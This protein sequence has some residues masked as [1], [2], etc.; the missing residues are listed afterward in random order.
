MEEKPKRRSIRDISPIDVYRLLPGTACKECGEPN[1]MA[2]A[3]RLVNGEVQLEDC[4]PLRT[5]EHQLRYLQL[6]ELL[7][8]A[9]R[10]VTFGSKGKAMT[11]GGKHVLLRHELTY[12]HPPPLAIEVSDRM[13][14]KEIEE[15]VRKVQAL[16]YLY[17]GRD[18]HLDA[19]AIRSVSGDAATFAS[20]VKKVVS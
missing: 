17:I 3:T 8:P 11:I 19:V 10:A 16:S 12:H 18:L 13:G 7:A 9:V 20:V 2:F 4:P 15:R 5:P 14:E 6:Q 1:C